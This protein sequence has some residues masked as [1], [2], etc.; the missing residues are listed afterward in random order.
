M[1]PLAAVAE[2]RGCLLVTTERVVPLVVRGSEI[3]VFWWACQ[4]GLLF[5]GKN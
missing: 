4:V 3:E 5:V 1:S 2:R